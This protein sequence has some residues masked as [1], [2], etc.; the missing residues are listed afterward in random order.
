MPK[1]VDRSKDTSSDVLRTMLDTAG[2]GFF[3]TTAAGRFIDA[4]DE[5][6]H[7][8][9]YRDVAAILAAGD[10]VAIHHYVD[11][12]ARKHMM[13]ILN[14]DGLIRK[15]PVVARRLDGTEIQTEV[16]AFGQ[17]DQSGALVGLVGTVADVSDLVAAQQALRETAAEYQRIFDSATEG[18]Y[19]SSRE[20]QAAARQCGA[21]RAQRLRH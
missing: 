20:G 16:S 2:I 15:H 10:D 6:A 11:P 17:Y 4:N 12:D 7:I 3:R 8:L 13:E 5:M 14:R 19:R 1:P 21:G 18:M 9:G